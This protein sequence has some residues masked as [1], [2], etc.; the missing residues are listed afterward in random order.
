MMNK[1]IAKPDITYV[2][3]HSKVLI[4]I[5]TI[6]LSV[7]EKPSISDHSLRPITTQPLCLPL[8]S[9]P[10]LLFHFIVTVRVISAEAEAEMEWN[11]FVSCDDEVAVTV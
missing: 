11:Q 5:L 9:P 2:I 1:R 3:F 10:S 6:A 8:L 4:Q 7:N